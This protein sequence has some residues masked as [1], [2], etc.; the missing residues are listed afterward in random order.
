[1]NKKEKRKDNKENNKN[2]KINNKLKKQTEEEKK[3]KIKKRKSLRWPILSLFIFLFII[4]QIVLVVLQ[5]LNIEKTNKE[6]IQNLK[7]SYYENKKKITYEAMQISFAIIEKKYSEFKIKE[8]ELIQND[9]S[10]LEILNLENRYKKEVI[11]ILRKIRYDN[12][13]GY[14]WIT[15]NTEPIPQVIMDSVFN[16]IEGGIP[17]GEDFNTVQNSNENFFKKSLEIALQKKEGYIEFLWKKPL[18]N[19]ELSSEN[20]PKLAYI[21]YF[22]QWNWIVGT[23]LYVDE[24]E[25]KIKQFQIKISYNKTRIFILFISV[26]SM[27]TIL[28]IIIG[29]I[30]LN[31][32]L[33]SHLN[34]VIN[35]SITIT[36]GDLTVK[37]NIKRDDEI[38]DLINSFSNMVETL[39]NLNHKI[40]VAIIILTKNLRTLFKSS[41]AVKDSANIQAVTVEQTLGNFE[42]MNK[43]VETISIESGKAN[44]Y[45]SQALKK[46][47]IGMES[48]ERLEAEMSKIENSSVEITNII[49]MIN[50]IAEQTN[51]LSLNASIESA[52]AGEAGKGF[53]IVAGEIRKLAEKSTNAANRIHE[54]I[55]NNNKIIKEGVKYSKDTTNILKDI[56]MSNELIA[57]LVKTISEEI[58]KMKLS[59]QE[60]LQAINNISDIAQANLLES[61]KVSAAMSDFVEQTL[62]L[63]KFVGQFDVRTDKI[64]EN[65]SH[66]EE[67]LKAKLIEVNK[68]LSEYGSQ[69][70]PTG[71]TVKI[72]DHVVQELRIGNLKVTGNIDLVDSISKKTNT[73]VTIF[74]TIED[75]LIRVATT[76]RN[77]D[78][79]R[80]IG[81]L[82]TKDSKV[83]QTV[84]SGKEYFGRAFVVNKWYVAVYKPIMD[85]T[86]YVL[87]AIYLG[88]P[89]EIELAK[90]SKYSNLFNAE[91]DGIMADNSFRHEFK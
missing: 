11:E 75:A 13:N 25:E 52:R 8:R 12:G 23:G 84:L 47:K 50:E 57:G 68:I 64:K 10:T 39:K 81:T 59:S 58:Q 67:I 14:F 44:S 17:E 51:L 78:N 15:D 88:I 38:G 24:L 36:K 61:E 60:I 55:T 27:S 42:N 79:T 16:S 43:M 40:Y 70:L 28:F 46:A 4:S 62:E 65:Q 77:F 89:E 37:F 56:A 86:G 30:Y 63:Q 74:Q 91:E 90:D 53:N 26:I 35:K 7:N 82:I 6:E 54:L 76:V 9:A 83:Y 29:N 33:L 45:T 1:M 2:K 19:N 80:A 20:F 32:K 48:M 87:G 3:E 18:E 21:K 85:E 71:E 31:R 5:L 34:E 41:F 66:I 73:S 69:F 49:G 22:R 72:G